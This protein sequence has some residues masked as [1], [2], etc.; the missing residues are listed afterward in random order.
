MSREEKGGFWLV[1][2]VIEPNFV[3]EFGFVLLATPIQGGSI[4]RW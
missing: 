3:M 4:P 2:D 1:L